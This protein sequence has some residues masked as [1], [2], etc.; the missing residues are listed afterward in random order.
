MAL[1]FSCLNG[2]SLVSVSSKIWKVV[3]YRLGV[4]VRLPLNYV[5]LIYNSSNKTRRGDS[6]VW[7]DFSE[8]KRE[9]V[10]GKFIMNYFSYVFM[11]SLKH[12]SH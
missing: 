5:V 9:N 11:L 7:K 4:I 3:K 12:G 10:V 6:G 1:T 2:D 8:F